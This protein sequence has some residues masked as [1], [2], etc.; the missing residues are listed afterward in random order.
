METER[1]VDSLLGL[2]VFARV[3]ELES[4]TAAAERLGLSKAS[5]SKQVARLEQRLGARLLNRTTRRLSLTEAGSVF[6]DHCKRILAEAEA[7]E[8]A[9][10]QLRASP[11]GLLRVNAGV[12][13]AAR[14]MGPVIKDFLVAHPGVTIELTVADR[15]VDL[16]EEGYD[17][18]VRIGRM[19]ETSLIA[20]R[21]SPI[22]PMIVASPAYL[23]RRGRPAEPQDLAG[24][25]VIGYAYQPSGDVLRL[26]G[27]GGEAAVRSS[28]RLKVNNGEV[29]LAAAEAGMGVAV[30]PSFISGDALRAGTLERVLPGWSMEPSILYAVYPPARPAPGKT[31]AFVDHLATV[32]GAEPYWDRGLLG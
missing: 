4:F 9:V 5:V 11:R 25:E 28:G 17:L 22:R 6:F 13:F 32:F 8:E 19:A 16:V 29:M 26:R 12:S 1:A 15:F 21:L 3:V 18:A 31:R 24:H 10:G 2:A 7:A 30:L 27:P 20:R 23:A 14:H